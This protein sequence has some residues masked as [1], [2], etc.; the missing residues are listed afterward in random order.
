MDT[1]KNCFLTAKNKTKQ[2]K[3]QTKKG[4]RLFVCERK[5]KN[6]KM[7][8][9]PDEEKLAIATHYLLSSPP[10][11]IK[12]VLADVKVVLNP[13]TLLTDGVLKGIFRKYNTQNFELV[14]GDGSSV[15]FHLLCLWNP[16]GKIKIK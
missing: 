5:K 13:P 6:R 14:E 9:I 2:K 11:E 3:D 12:E 15:S 1:Q 7:S 16:L 10:A 8:E 4:K